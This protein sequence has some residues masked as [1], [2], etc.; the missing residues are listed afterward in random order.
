MRVVI[1]GGGIVGL[2]VA[3]FLRERGAEVVVVD[4]GRCGQGTSRGNTGWITPGISSDPLAAPGVVGQA[5]RWTLRRTSPFSIQPRPSLDLARWLWGFWRSSGPEPYRRGMNALVRLNARTLEILD[6]FTA[7]GVAFEMYRDG[8]L[9]PTLSAAAA[10]KIAATYAR[11]RAAGYH[12]Q[13]HELGRDDIHELEPALGPA[14]TGGAYSV[15]ERHVRP[16]TL[17]SGLV[18][19]LARSGVSLLEDSG[20][21]ALRR[22]SSGWRLTLEH[23]ELRADVV[24]VASGSWSRPL[25]AGLGVRL[26]LRSGKGYSVTASGRGTR[27]ARPLYM[28]ESRVA[29]SPYEPDLLRIGGTLEVTAYDESLTRRRLDLLL[30]VTRQYLGDWRAGAVELEWAGLRPLVPDSL[31]VVGPIPGHQGLYVATGH[32]MIGMTAGPPSGLELA[33]LILDGREGETIRPFL[34]ARLLSS[35]RWVPSILRHRATEVAMP[36]EHTLSGEFI[37]HD[38]DRSRA[39]ALTVESGDTRALDAGSVVT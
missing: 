21:T 10:R 19:A 28:V 26:P 12:G 6:R 37:H 15:D 14:V 1:V 5:L 34:P 16:E 39:P 20:V 13:V 7:S 23:D 24:V 4:R 17:T 36:R 9:Y 25:L 27:P 11:L 8:L 31:P 30:E 18:D 38:Q 32:G 29:L 22:H 2:S 33:N 35:R 3:Y